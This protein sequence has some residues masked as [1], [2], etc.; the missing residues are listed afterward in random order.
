VEDDDICTACFRDS[1]VCSKDP[2][3]AVEEDRAAVMPEP[4]RDR[5]KN[6]SINFPES[7]EEA[8]QALVHALRRMLLD[9]SSAHAASPLKREFTTDAGLGYE[10]TQCQAD[11][12]NNARSI[13]SAR[14]EDMLDSIDESAKEPT[15]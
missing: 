6:P 11:W 15:S 2:C 10:R 5:M 8:F 9:T 3:E 13:I 7:Q 12:L 1:L 4:P 14:F